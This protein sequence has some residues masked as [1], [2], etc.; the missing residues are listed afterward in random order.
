MAN[1]LTVINQLR[2]KIISQR[3]VD[4]KLISRRVSKNTTFNA[5]EIHGILRLFTQEANAAMQTGETVKIDDL[6]TS[7]PT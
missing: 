2:P 3:I 7:N 1:R 4:L 5:E 6:V